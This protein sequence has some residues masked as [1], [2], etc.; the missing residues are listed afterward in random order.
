MIP[1]D[2]RLMEQVFVNLLDNAVKHSEPSDQITITVEAPER[3]S[4]IRIEVADRGEGTSDADLPNIFETFYTSSTRDADSKQGIGLGLAIC[5]TI[6][7]A[8]GGSIRAE[9]RA[10]GKGAVFTLKI[11]V[12]KEE[13]SNGALS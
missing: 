10:D 13:G 3:E 11:P 6:I 12:N 8:H 5:D 9:N 1:M 4:G 2:A 7:K